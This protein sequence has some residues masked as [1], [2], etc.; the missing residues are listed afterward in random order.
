MC[1][2]DHE[3]K[4]CCCCVP[5]PQGPQGVD[6][7]QGIPGQQGLQGPMGAQGPQGPQ[8]PPGKDCE[9]HCCQPCYGSIYSL[10]D[11]H[12]HQEGIAGD[13]ATF[14]HVSVSYGDCL[15]WSLASQGIVKV[16]K[17][18]DYKL[19]WSANGML[20][21]PFNSPVPS[22]G[23]G[24]YKNGAI[25]PGTAVAGFSQSPD[26]DATC[27]TQLLNASLLAG[28]ML[29]LKN[30]STFPIFLKAQHSELVVPMTSASLSILKLN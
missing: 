2:E 29:V 25:I 23:L 9:E 4:R 8:G 5:G 22:W 21:P 12:I 26:D 19:E 17:S 27:L 11:Q 10:M 1:R 20:A 14:E 13:I 24:I 18:G 15:D 28:D 30:I 16:L 3:Y 7:P 6:G